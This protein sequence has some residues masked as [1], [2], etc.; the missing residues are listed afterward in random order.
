MALEGRVKRCLRLTDKSHSLNL[1]ILYKKKVKM[2]SRLIRQ[3]GAIDNLMYSSKNIATVK[4]ELG[5]VDYVFKQLVR[6]YEEYHSMSEEEN[7]LESEEWFEKVDERA[8]SFNH[9][10]AE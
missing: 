7:K 1:P 3:S 5:Q 4:E 2:N 10:L 8:F 6:V 9:R